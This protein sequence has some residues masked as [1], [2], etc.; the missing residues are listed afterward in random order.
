[1]ISFSICR[2][3]TVFRKERY[4]LY[5]CPDGCIRM[6]SLWNDYCN[7]NSP[8]G[9]HSGMIH[10]NYRFGL[11]C[12][13]V[14]LRWGYAH[15]RRWCVVKRGRQISLWAI[16]IFL[17]RE[18]MECFIGEPYFI[19]SFS[20]RISFPVHFYR[21]MWYFSCGSF[22]GISLPEPGAGVCKGTWKASVLLLLWW[23]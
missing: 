14:C 5:F 4:R 20:R 9:R 19:L 13:P 18:C 1:M 21:S 8:A 3:L 6:A 10:W 22:C 15:L 2:P 16:C 23:W 7:G 12:L 17:F 11:V